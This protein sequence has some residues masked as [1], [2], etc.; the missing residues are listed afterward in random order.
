M[1]QE[2]KNATLIPLHKK[3]DGKVCDDHQGIA[4]LIIPGKVLSLI[5]LERLHAIIDPQL[6]ESQCGFRKGRG[7][8]DQIW[9][10]R[11]I[12]EGAAECETAAHLCYVDIKAYDSVD[13]NALIAIL[14]SYRVPCHLIDIIKEMYTDTRLLTG[15]S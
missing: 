8:T 10:T 7:T 3:K 15:E 14:K 2:W 4:L 1:P 13:R 5:L 9:L 12:V 11:Q 6:L